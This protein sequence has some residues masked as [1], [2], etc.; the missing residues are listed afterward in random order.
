M[1]GWFWGSSGREVVIAPPY[2]RACMRP[3]GADSEA[4]VVGK[5]SLHPLILVFGCAPVGLILGQQ[6]SGKLSGWLSGC[7]C[8][9]PATWPALYGPCI[10]KQLGTGQPVSPENTT[11]T[12]KAGLM[13]GPAS[14]QLRMNIE[15]GESHKPELNQ[16]LTAF[17]AILFS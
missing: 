5:L 2:P 17:P 8:S 11:R 4:A 12:H 16:N 9:L 7:G 14:T 10:I 6:W 13:L 3:C 1:W 15:I